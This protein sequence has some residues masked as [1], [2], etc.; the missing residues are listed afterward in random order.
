MGC[1]SSVNIRIE[2]DGDNRK[3]LANGK[4]V[5]NKNKRK[6]KIDKIEEHSNEDNYDASLN[7]DKKES[8]Q[9]KTKT[10]TNDFKNQN[11]SDNLFNNQSINFKYMRENKPINMIKSNQI[12]GNR[13]DIDYQYK[14]I[15]IRHPIDL[16]S[17]FSE[18]NQINTNKEN[19]DNKDNNNKDNN[20][21]YNDNVEV[22][23]IMEERI[24][25][26]NGNHDDDDGGNYDEDGV[27]QNSYGAG[28]ND[29]MC[30]LGVS[31]D[32]TQAKNNNNK[33]EDE[34]KEISVI[35]EIQSTGVKHTI[36]VNQNIKLYELIEKFKKSIKF[37]SF[38][39]PEFVFNAVFL[40]EYDKPISDF[41]IINNS[42]INV[43]V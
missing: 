15:S 31:V 7:D 27:N 6:I 34:N 29:D 8:N 20:D 41:K 33:K 30:N 9:N 4:E 42:K 13:K 19:E 36:K 10:D 18:S 21:N 40:I 16:S 28:D 24:N 38:E 43:Y 17:E 25:N 37:S 1:T 32:I 35:F 14:F 23:N 2:D 26:F 11:I 22:M 12:N 3:I 39:K 5:G